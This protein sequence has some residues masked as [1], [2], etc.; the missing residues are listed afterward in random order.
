MRNALGAVLRAVFRPQPLE[1][2]RKSKNLNQA[3]DRLNGEAEKI[4][5]EASN[6]STSY[7]LSQIVE[8][9]K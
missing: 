3:L 2:P 9:I 1:K 6:N 4:K 7:T 5:Q 8:R